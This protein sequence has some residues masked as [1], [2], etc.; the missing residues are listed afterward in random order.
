MGYKIDLTGEKFGHLT[1]ISSRR[2]RKGNS[3]KTYWKC[4]CDCGNIIEIRMERLRNGVV[5]DCG[6]KCPYH[7]KHSYEDLTGMRFGKLIVSEKLENDNWKCR[8]D[9]GGVGIYSKVSLVQG[10]KRDCGCV[11]RGDWI[12]G[13]KYEML[14]IKRII[15]EKGEETKVECLCDCGNTKTLSL[16]RVIN[17]K[18]KSCGCLVPDKLRSVRKTHGKSKSRIYKIWKKMNDRCRNVNN[19]DYDKYGGRDIEI[20]PEW[21]GEHGAENFI[22]WAYE[23]GYDENAEKGKCTIDRINVDGNYEPSNCRWINM[24]EQSYNRRNTIRIS[25]YGEMLTVKEISEKYNIPAKKVRR[26]YF[27]G[28]RDEERLLY[29]GNLGEL[30]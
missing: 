22:K 1:A 6:V 30:R 16:T 21:S 8:C 7:I 23:N 9:C 11:K 17:K 13:K 24:I 29:K 28:I 27:Y 15:R 4:K 18:V 2:E 25:V 10:W 26:R 19:K 12:I 20:S 3:A 14:T 5:K